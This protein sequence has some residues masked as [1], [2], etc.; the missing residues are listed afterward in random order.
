[1]I[2]KRPANELPDDAPLGFLNPWL[3]S[4]EVL[5]LMGGP[6]LNDIVDGSNPGCGTQGFPAK[7]GWDPVRPATLVFLK[8]HHWLIWRSL[9]PW[10]R[11]TKLT[12]V[13]VHP[14][15]ETISRTSSFYGANAWSGVNAVMITSC[16]ID[17]SYVSAIQIREIKSVV[18]PLRPPAPHDISITQS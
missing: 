2:A 3:N 7:P 15:T 1:M 18:I 4:D 16:R 14:Q 10:S 5:N 11:D 6:D 8:F 13:A 12:K 17:L 9:G